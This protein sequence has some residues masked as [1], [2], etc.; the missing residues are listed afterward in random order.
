MT[1][2]LAISLLIL[3]MI[4]LTGC[5]AKTDKTSLD[6]YAA[7]NAKDQAQRMAAALLRD[8]FKTV[9]LYTYPK[10]VDLFG[11]EEKMAAALRAGKDA[12]AAKGMTVESI[13]VGEA[14]KPTSYGGN[15]FSVVKQTIVT[16]TS[17]GLMQRESYYLG[18]SSD[19]GK[20]W[21]FVDGIGMSDQGAKQVLPPLPSTVRLPPP[22]EPKELK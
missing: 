10:V 18:I 4:L 3:P 17:K 1:R 21:T 19:A 8:D 15:T 11:G 22:S 6:D 20:T 2:R 16:K 5:N 7:E 13:S 12:G 9:A 14:S